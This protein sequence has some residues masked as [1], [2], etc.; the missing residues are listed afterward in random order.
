MTTEA[1]VVGGDE[2][3]A[4]ETN[5]N[6]AVALRTQNLT[7]IRQTGRTVFLQNNIF[8]KTNHYIQ[9][10]RDY[11]PEE[12]RPKLIRYLHFRGL[13]W[14]I[15]ILLA[16]ALFSPAFYPFAFV[17]VG[18]SIVMILLYAQY[19]H[20]VRHTV[21]IMLRL[22][23][24]PNDLMKQYAGNKLNALY[25][26]KLEDYTAVFAAT[27]EEAIGAVVKRGSNIKIHILSTQARNDII[28]TRTV[29]IF[30]MCTAIFMCCYCFVF[31]SIL[32]WRVND[33]F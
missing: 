21:P 2:I 15:L 32:A 7:E 22:P 5:A 9:Q 1:T 17:M 33:D 4:A 29:S 28:N 14:A 31:A 11:V 26:I 27:P 19:M 10:S 13:H 16:I 8:S 18:V 23:H 30:S 24:L 20:V 25:E 6:I 3:T 12:L